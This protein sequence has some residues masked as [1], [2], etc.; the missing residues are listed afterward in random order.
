MYRIT[1]DDWDKWEHLVDHF[2]VA[3]QLAP[4]IAKR[5]LDGLSFPDMDMLPFGFISMGDCPD[6][7][8]CR[9]CNLTQD[10]QT[11]QM[12]L[13][14]IFRSPLIFGGDM[15]RL[16]NF[17]LSLLTNSLVLRINAM[18][19]NNAALHRPAAFKQ[20]VWHAD[21]PQSREL[22]V[23]L[24][25]LDDVQQNVDFDFIELDAPSKCQIWDV[26][27]GRSIGMFTDTFV[28]PLRAHASAYLR[29]LC[30]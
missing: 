14:S 23:A 30:T 10:E 12:T 27:T 15:R 16:D 28:T 29:L 1:G 22:Y 11:T 18:S 6:G 26:W 24:F 25:N 2:D 21:D 13:W 19:V 7:E 9:Y 8:P 3:E 5:G 20:A 17:T 4:A